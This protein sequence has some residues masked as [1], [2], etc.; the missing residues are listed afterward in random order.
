MR[1]TIWGMEYCYHEKLYNKS[2]LAAMIADKKGEIF[3]KA[4]WI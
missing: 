3:I 1:I 2:I 4:T